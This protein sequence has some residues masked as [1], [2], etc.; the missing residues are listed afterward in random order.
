MLGH[1]HTEFLKIMDEIKDGIRYAFQTKNDVTLAV[2]AS[3]HGAMEC[4]C[5]NMVERGESV[6]VGVNGIWGER[7]ADMVDRH[8]GVAHKLVKP[9]G[10]TYSLEEVEK[11]LK[12][13]QPTVAFF[14]HGDSS[15][16]TVQNLVGLGD[17]CH[18]YNCLLIV[19]SVASLGGVPLLMDQWGID[20]L[21]SCSQKV[22]SCPPGAS[23]ISFS[24][25]AWKKVNSRKTRIRSF[26]LDITWLAS[27]WECASL[28]RK[29][30]HTSPIQT[31]YALREGLAILAEEGLEASWNRHK[32]CAKLLHDGISDLHLEFLVANP[33]ERL[34]T[35]TAIKVPDGVD[36]KFVVDYAMKQY[37]VEIAGGLGAMAG[38]V[39]RIGIQ[40]YN[41]T[42]DNIR[43]V[44]R[45]LGE[46]LEQLRQQQSNK[47]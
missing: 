4:A 32:E 7:F 47:L 17:L 26:Y 35:V 38:K 10:Q 2:S 27:Y 18:K 40:G 8:E 5:C 30:H 33:E 1:L 41:A 3:G 34:P 23:P 9:Y 37:K 21:Y 20:V 44:L 22:L 36:W 12:E 6:L 14:V 46:G 28:S 24:E 13:H 39:W 11:A 15:G 29:Y 42:A 19:D 43:L 31:M 45:G 25:A 16:G